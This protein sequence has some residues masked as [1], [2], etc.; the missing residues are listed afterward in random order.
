MKHICVSF[1]SLITAP[2]PHYSCIVLPSA[3]T[4]W[5]QLEAFDAHHYSTIFY[6]RIFTNFIVKLLKDSLKKFKFIS[7]TPVCSLKQKLKQ[8]KEERA[9]L[10]L[11]FW[12][13]LSCNFALH[14]SWNV[15]CLCL[16][17]DQTLSPFQSF[18]QFNY[19][20]PILQ[21]FCISSSFAHILFPYN[22]FSFPCFFK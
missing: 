18:N 2:T 19:H 9:I 1:P 7:A 15:A 14:A 20:F 6:L 13:W 8:E 22:P 16:L 21:Q 4:P 3:L 11:L 5:Y 10:K 17:L 12:K